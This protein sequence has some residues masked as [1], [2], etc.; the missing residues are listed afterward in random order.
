MAASN[1]ITG[2]VMNK[3]KYLIATASLM[4]SASFAQTAPMWT[5]IGASEKAFGEMEVN[6]RGSNAGP[7]FWFPGHK[8]NVDGPQFATPY[9]TF[10]ATKG[11]ILPSKQSDGD[12][13]DR[14]ECGAYDLNGDGKVDLLCVHGADSGTGTGEAE[15][16]RN[17][18]TSTTGVMTRLDWT[19]TGLN[20]G[21]AV[22]GR[23]RSATFFKR[24]DGRLAVW[25]ATQ[26]E[27]R[28]DNKPNINRVFVQ[29]T[30][31][32]FKFQEY[33][34]PVINQEHYSSCTR[35]GDING[36]GLDD[37]L[38][39]RDLEWSYSAGGSTLVPARTL[40]YYQKADNSFTMST[41]PQISG[42]N[43]QW[44]TAR[45]YDWDADGR[46]DL[47]VTSTAKVPRVMVFPQR[48]D[49]TIRATPSLSVA[50]NAPSNSIA[51]GDLNGDG[52]PDIYVT[53]AQYTE[54]QRAGNT[55]GTM[56]D[57]W[58]DFVVMSRSGGGYTS[59]T[60]TNEPRD[61]GCS[62]LA[63]FA[64]NKR[65]YLARGTEG[66]AGQ[67]YVVDFNAQARSAR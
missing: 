64:G 40:V 16:F 26:G 30:T 20:A 19:Q 15:L 9:G 43:A 51:I 67:G 12:G 42:A 32:P 63:T 10:S 24:A 45:I 6:W 58:P 21:D 57:T 41:L 14:H 2:E 59:Q 46:K 60:I 25:I 65:V 27:R 49:G 53:Q 23:K 54:C 48:S 13:G 4:A 29:S 35:A 1:C 50:L 39:C 61:N 37:L 31:D 18:S 33:A 8:R 44:R 56:T 34:D 5:P 52:L 55:K 17:E 7:D 38:M 3:L 28:S 66:V 62:W 47:V 22:Y 36:D 11:F